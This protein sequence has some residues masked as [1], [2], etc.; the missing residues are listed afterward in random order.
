MK[1]LFLR[2]CDRTAPTPSATSTDLDAVVAA[3][4]ASAGALQE[5]V[6]AA[7]ASE[8]WWPRRTR[9]GQ[10][11]TLIERK[12]DLIDELSLAALA[13]DR[14]VTSGW[15]ALEVCEQLGVLAD[16]HVMADFDGSL[17]GCPAGVQAS[18]TDPAGDSR[19]FD[20][21][22]R[23]RR[24]LALRC[25]DVRRLRSRGRFPSL[26]VT[27][28]EDR[29]PIAIAVPTVRAA[30]LG[31]WL[32]ACPP[33]GH[34]ELT[35]GAAFGR[36]A[37]RSIRDV[38]GLLDACLGTP[39]IGRIQTVNLQHI[40]LAACSPVFREVI[41]ASPAI[42]AD[43]WPVVHML[44]CNGYPAV[45]RVTGADLVAKLLDDPRARGLR[46]ALV[47]G[48]ECP[49]TAFEARARAAGASVVVREHGDK[50]DWVPAVLAARLNESGASLALVAVTQ[51]AGD[52]LAAE[53]VGAGYRGTAIGIGAAVE[54]F[55]GGERRAAQWIQ[56]LGLEWL[57]R[58]AQNPR[59][60][61][62]RYFVEGVPTYFGVVRPIIRSRSLARFSR[63][64]ALP[65]H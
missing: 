62:R 2:S 40:H 13:C 42:T 32:L 51:P 6:V 60:L 31:A 63:L 26:L 1:V 30:D 52:L 61:W 18:D 29:D 38:D 5:V 53:L 3:R 22:N 19:R 21:T 48:S 4:L 57:F 17:D 34:A 39:G 33:A 27:E 44:R 12:N 37:P 54:L 8:G 43:G 46:L 50:R 10:G 55:V 23:A 36:V 59:R 35:L 49:G 20:L 56:D 41:A 14:L 45:E 64:E 24:I 47:G 65:V 7:P 9:H 58:F 11:T 15:P 16:V 28:R 25:A